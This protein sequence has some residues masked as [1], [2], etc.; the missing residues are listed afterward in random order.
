MPKYHVFS[1]IVAG[2][3]SD[4]LD[5]A[6]VNKDLTEETVSL[7]EGRTKG[8][9]AIYGVH[10]V[11]NTS[12][13]YD[14]SAKYNDDTKGKMTFQYPA[15]GFNSFYAITRLMGRSITLSTFPI[16]SSPMISCRWMARSMRRSP[17]A[18]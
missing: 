2:A 17:V 15:D 14:I 5:L 7:P 13:L 18:T 11:N 3:N 12:Q 1:S 16:P 10:D 4:A 9:I 8:S 6:L